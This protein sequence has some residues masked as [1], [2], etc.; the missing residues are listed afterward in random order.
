MSL[1]AV[2]EELQRRY[3][4]LLRSSLVEAI[5]RRLA[6]AERELREVE[7]ELEKLRRRYGTD[8]EEFEKAMDDSLEAHEAWIEWRFL[9][10]AKK[11]LEEEIGELRQLLRKALG[12]VPGHSSEAREA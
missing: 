8:L 4:G 1:G 2:A 12:E 6:E 5:R 11:S 3:P 9:H 7:A 10:E